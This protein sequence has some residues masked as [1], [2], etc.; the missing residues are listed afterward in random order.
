MTV[1]E[2]IRSA[3][4]NNAKDIVREQLLTDDAWLVR[5]LIAIFNR[6]TADEQQAER[7]EI[8]NKM[9]F[10][11]SDAE[12]LTSFAK[13]WQQKEWLSDK[14]MGIIRRKLPKYSAQLARI[15]R[16]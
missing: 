14:Q 11:S 3:S 5:G 2:R 7:T 4:F 9:G 8:H 15:A 1:A 13:Q 16:G 12:I 6:Q 10:N